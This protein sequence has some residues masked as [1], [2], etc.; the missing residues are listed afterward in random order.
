M[1]FK[2]NY[3]N[4]NTFKLTENIKVYLKPIL[5]YIKISKILI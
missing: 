2:I 1:K 5:N 4:L 3:F